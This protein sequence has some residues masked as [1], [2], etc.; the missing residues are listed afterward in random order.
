[1]I[2]TQLDNY[3]VDEKIGE[4]GMGAVYRAYDV[5]LER[6]AALKFL[7]P[8][9]SAQPDLIERF[10]SEA[11]AVARLN[12]ANV[13]GIYGLH[14]HQTDLFMAMEFVPGPTLH[15][16]IASQGRLP[17]GHAVAIAAAVLSALEYAHAQGIVH[18][19][20]KTANI[21]VRPDG[22]VKVMDFGIARV[23][24]SQRH[25]RTGF[26]VGTLAYMAP[27]QIQGLE[28]DGRA[29]IYSLGIVLY[30]MLSGR[31][32]FAGGT[33]WQMMQ[34]HIS[35]APPPLSSSVEVPEEVERVVMRALA[36]EPVDRFAS[37][38]EFRRALKASLP[39]GAFDAAVE[40]AGVSTSRAGASGPDD[41]TV[42]RSALAPTPP[43]GTVPAAGSVAATAVARETGAGATAEPGTPTTTVP[44]GQ[45]VTPVP[46]VGATAVPARSRRPLAIAAGAVVLVGAAAAVW[47]TLGARPAP[48][49]PKTEASAASVA[50]PTVPAPGPAREPAPVGTTGTAGSTVASPEKPLVPPQPGRT[51]PEASPKARAAGAPTAPVQPVLQFDKVRLVTQ[52]GN[53]EREVNVLLRFEGPRLAAVVPGSL[54]ELRSV[55]YRDITSATYAQRRGGGFLGRGTRHWLELEGRMGSLAFRLDKSN[56]QRIVSELE[57]RWGHAVATDVPKK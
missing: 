34:S 23:L 13:A 19:D 21:I 6:E 56:G 47:L 20:I 38:T 52:A 53:T 46:A 11:K 9:L 25:T 5:M 3:R 14:H 27:E 31:T 30:E 57:R 45:S 36:K 10:R 8:E 39:P 43:L 48:V 2:G 15:E 33:D 26:A 54:T 35:M 4:G 16:V 51:A 55:A 12:H 29:D 41:E 32:P 17:V 44:T 18:R 50:P 22:R 42:V 24:G 28:V 1:M 37:A 7:R 40:E 49:P